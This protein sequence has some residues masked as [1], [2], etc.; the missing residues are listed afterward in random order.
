MEALLL[1]IFYVVVL[2]FITCFYLVFENPKA[3]VLALGALVF[4]RLVICEAIY[5]FIKKA[6]PYQRLKFVPYSS[7]WLFSFN[8]IRQD[9]M[10]SGHSAILAAISVV[11]YWFFPWLGPAWIVGTFLNGIARV[12]LGYHDPKDVVAGWI[13]GT[14]SGFLALYLG[15]I[16]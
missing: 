15:G 3:L 6:R 12:I 8:N 14:A 5:F 10:P 16:L 7:N 4:A 11:F 9:A 13:V 1:P 2:L